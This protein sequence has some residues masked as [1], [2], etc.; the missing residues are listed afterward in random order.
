MNT[1]NRKPVVLVNSLEDLSKLQ[2]GSPVNLNFDD[3]GGEFVYNGRNG[4]MVE[5]ARRENDG[6]IKLSVALGNL[7]FYA[8]VVN[9]HTT[10]DCNLSFCSPGTSGYYELNRVLAR[11]GR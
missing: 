2:I 1:E 3:N 6:A 8:G 4:N 10:S 5:F 7:R 11:A 9:T